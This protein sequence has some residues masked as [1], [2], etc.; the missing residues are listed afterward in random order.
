MSNYLNQKQY[1]IRLLLADR[2]RFSDVTDTH[3]DRVK[4]V[5]EQV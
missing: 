1:V 5:T 4:G 2:Q 3:A